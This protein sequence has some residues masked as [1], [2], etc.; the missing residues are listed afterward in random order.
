MLQHSVGTSKFQRPTTTHNF[1]I[2]VLGVFSVI[3]RSGEEERKIQSEK[4]TL[5]M[6]CKYSDPSIHASTWSVKLLGWWENFNF[7]GIFVF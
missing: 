2:F 7:E 3:S 5:K 1:E 4:E 6:T